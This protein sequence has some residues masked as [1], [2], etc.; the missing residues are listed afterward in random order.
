MKK[1]IFTSITALILSSC[2]APTNLYTWSKYE[3]SSYNY[4]KNNDEK[5]NANLEEE[6]K[7]I[8][9]KQKGIRGIVPPGVYADYGFFLLQANRVD[10][11]K[12]MLTK[13]M[14]LYPESKIFLGKIIKMTE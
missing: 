9:K 12:A 10:E 11:G 13:E 2:S 14:E 6:Y 5:S 3:K 4:L 1:I 8:I 7:N